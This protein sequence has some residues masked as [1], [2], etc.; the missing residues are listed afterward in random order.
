LGY[1]ARLGSTYL[2]AAVSPE[3]PL[4]ITTAPLEAQKINT[5][6]SAEDIRNEFGAI[7]SRTSFVGGEGLDFA[8]QPDKD[9]AEL[10]GRFWASEHIDISNPSP[11]EPA[12]LSL[13]PPTANIE[14]S[15]DTNLHLAWDGTRLHMAE[16]TSTRRST[17]YTAATP[18]FT[19]SDPNLAEGA[20]TIND[21]TTLG[22]V[23]YAVMDTNGLHE[24]VAGT[25]N[26][27]NN[28]TAKKCWG[29]KLLLLV[30]TGT[31]LA[32]ANVSS[33]AY[34]TR[35]TLPAGREWLDVADCGK[36]I[37]AAGSDGNV[38][39]LSNVSGTLTLQAQTP[40]EG[41]QVPYCVGFD[42]KY[43][44]VGTREATPSGAIGRMW[45]A[46]LGDTYELVNAQLLKQWG[47]QSATIDHAPRKIIRARGGIVFGVY[48]TGGSFLWRYD[49]ATGGLSRHLDLVA[50]GLVVD[51]ASIDGR[52][53]ATV[54][55]HGLR[56]E[57]VGSYETEG[58]LMGPL[59]DL[60][61][62]SAKSWAGAFIDGESIS[63]DER[64][65]L[66]YTTDPSALSDATS[67]AWVRVKS[68]VSG[69]DT[70]ETPLRSVD[71]RFLAGM[72]K[73]YADTAL[74][75]SP[76]VRSFAFRAYP[77]PGDVEVTLAVN[78]SDWYERP[79]QKPKLVKGMGADVYD[80]LAGKEG[81]YEELELLGTGETFRGV[82]KQVGTRI[83]EQ[84]LRGSQSVVTMLTFRGRRVSSAGDS[85][86]S[87]AFAIA[88]FGISFFGGREVAA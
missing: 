64:I 78:T 2:R 39:A 21:L 77:G 34:T 16:G 69:Q 26:S 74:T 19:G 50:S 47:D 40:M 20:Q 63:S 56:R 71:S 25:W 23:M 17:D 46:E 51:I 3:R 1:T 37:L 62:A 55:G 43:V 83:P 87:G 13:L 4:D 14:E 29:A 7:F 33:G 38:F 41:G 81:R 11:G 48:E 42:G 70:D 49:S 54:S 60:F 76:S 36:A 44:F 30:S 5:A 45:R 32:E 27:L 84:S 75:T 53:F 66:Y 57:K 59:G 52:L 35:A 12:K 15:T 58:Y 85:Q 31:V 67:A 10:L 28:T 8:H 6:N 73:L 65:E 9:P 18:S 72:V 88:S 61:T 82:V 68:V 80:F 79:G 22:N 86:S 24:M